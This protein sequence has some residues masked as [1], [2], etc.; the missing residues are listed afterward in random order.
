MGA[1]LILALGLLWVGA[2]FGASPGRFEG[3]VIDSHTGK[4]IARATVHI[5][6]NTGPVW[7]RTNRAGRFEI[8]AVPI[9]SYVVTVLAHG[10]AANR[11]RAL[12]CSGGTSD[13]DV[14]LA[15]SPTRA[16]KSYLPVSETLK[17]IRGSLFVKASGA[18]LNPWYCPW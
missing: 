18:G 16:T 3:R 2:G 9:G 7:M 5:I 12:S 4:P 14:P 15:P 8:A 1:A 13:A 11:Y 6:T 10:Y 17:G